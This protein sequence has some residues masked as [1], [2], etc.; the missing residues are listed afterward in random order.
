MTSDLQG[1][2]AQLICKNYD[3]GLADYLT[4]DPSRK[5]LYSISSSKVFAMVDL[6]GSNNQVRLSCTHL[7]L[8]V[9]E[10]NYWGTCLLYATAQFAEQISTTNFQVLFSFD[11]YSAHAPWPYGLA[12][13]TK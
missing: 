9:T 7:K 8:S 6:T 3:C 4:I 1:K 12:L 2:N 11:S 10:S 13:Y 5:K